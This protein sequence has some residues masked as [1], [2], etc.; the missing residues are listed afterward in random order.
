MFDG[1]G[2]KIVV[3]N[4]GKRTG[5]ENARWEITP[6]YG[7]K[8]KENKSGL[9]CAYQSNML[10]VRGKRAARVKEHMLLERKDT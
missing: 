9:E 5:V 6:T 1:I 8:L 10:M 2:K 7:E 3:G 4:D